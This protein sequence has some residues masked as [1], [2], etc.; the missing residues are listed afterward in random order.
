MKEAHIIRTSSDDSN[1]CIICLVACYSR[2]YTEHHIHHN[3]QWLRTMRRTRLWTAMMKYQ[4]VNHPLCLAHRY[5]CH[6]Q[7]YLNLWCILQMLTPTT[8]FVFCFQPSL[9][10][11]FFLF[12]SISK[13]IKQHNH[14]SIKI[15]GFFLIP[16]EIL[17]KSSILYKKN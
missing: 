17:K 10:I 1:C 13:S 6:F 12:L 7:Y 9:I 14:K 5:W 4:E 11:L 3:H 2:D 8:V 16:K 15:S